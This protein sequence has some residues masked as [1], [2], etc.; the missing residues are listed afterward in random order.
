MAH[1]NQPLSL[2]AQPMWHRETVDGTAPS[3][4]AAQYF[5][6]HWAALWVGE[7][8]YKRVSVGLQSSYSLTPG[9]QNFKTLKHVE[10]GLLRPPGGSTSAS[11]VYCLL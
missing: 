4:P 3:L 6:G 9:P 2:L 7:P 5:V 8:S 10:G 1:I 11:P